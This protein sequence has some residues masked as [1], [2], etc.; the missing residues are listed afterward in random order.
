VI[1]M[2]FLERDG[3]VRIAYE[4]FNPTGAGVPILLSHGFSATSAMWA[5]NVDALAADRTVVAWN[6]RGHGESD[7]PADPALYGREICLGDMA[8]LLDCVG[9]QRAILVGMSLGGYL[10]LA[11]HL[12]HPERVAAL[13]LVDTGPG[14][15]KDAAREDWNE[16]AR[17]RGDEIERAGALGSSLSTEVRRAQHRDLHGVAQAARHVLTQADSS[18]IDSLPGIDVPTLVVVG[19]D[20]ANF[21]GA[22]DYMTRTIPGARKVL[23]EDAGHASNLDQPA[24]FNAAVTEFLGGL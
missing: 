5:P 4:V 12:A 24:V 17:Q 8:A 19:S 1:G 7:S 21:L 16:W 20:D 13:V 23:I 2:Q 9:A 3:G 6:Q 15:R 14:F 10:S 11:F 22:A 18:V